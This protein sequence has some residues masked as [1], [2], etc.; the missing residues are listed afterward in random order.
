MATPMVVIVSKSIASIQV[1]IT[2]ATKVQGL[3]LE[4]L[5]NLPLPSV[6]PQ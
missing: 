2:I 6:K 4:D 3:D 1:A 5:K